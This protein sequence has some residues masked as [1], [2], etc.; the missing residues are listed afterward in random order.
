MKLLAGLLLL[1]LIG[2][3]AKQ[4]PY[5]FLKESVYDWHGEFHRPLKFITPQTLLTTSDEI[6]LAEWNFSHVTLAGK[7]DCTRLDTKDLGPDEIVEQV[8]T[9]PANKVFATIGTNIRLWETATLRLKFTIH[10]K[11]Q[12]GKFSP[13]GKQLAVYDQDQGLTIY[14]VDTGQLYASLKP[15]KAVVA[16]TFTQDGKNVLLQ[17]YNDRLLLWSL[18]EGKVFPQAQMPVVKSEVAVFSSDNKWLVFAQDHTLHLV[19]LIRKVEKV[20][21]EDSNINVAA[22]SADNSAL[23]L[24]TDGVARVYNTKT[25]LITHTIDYGSRVLEVVI[26]PDGKLLVTEDNDKTINLWKLLR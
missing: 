1:I 8:A 15:A 6:W 21:Q 12:S 16:L 23:V 4:P 25:W 14:H 9:S 24:G 20:I 22:F 13:D 17:P 3:H 11:G 26:S 5:S 19:D 2:Q 18:P 7:P 10:K